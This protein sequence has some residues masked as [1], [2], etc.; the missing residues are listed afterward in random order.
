VP[1]IPSLKAMGYALNFE[2]YD[3]KTRSRP[4]ISDPSILYPSTTV[5][6]GEV[7]Y[8]ARKGGG[9]SVALQM[10]KPEDG[11]DLQPGE[12]YVGGVPGG[13]RH[14]GGSNYAFVDGHVKWYRPEQ[15]KAI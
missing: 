7:S 12:S 11:S 15:W 6:L 8:V 14:Q 3:E 13:L 2:L 1:G 4:A 9:S 10:S 5:A